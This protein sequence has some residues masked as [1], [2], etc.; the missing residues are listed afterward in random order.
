M[1]LSRMLTTKKFAAWWLMLAAGVVF[2]GIG[3]FA[4]ID[5]LNSYLKL[6]KFTGIALLL[7]GGMLLTLAI[8]NTKYPGER[9]W[10]QAESILHLFFG[11]L[12]LFNPLLYFI[13]LPFFIGVWVLLVGVLKIFAAISLRHSIRGWMFI[14]L[15][16]VICALFGTLLIFIPLPKATG[17]TVLIGVFGL[18][19]GSLYTFDAYRYRKTPESI[20]MML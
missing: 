12:F 11:I 8:L 5:P 1:Y 2:I 17:I 3:L 10:Q 9:K 6:V 18:I 4:F 7:N 19:M 15:V 16:G 20:G 14:L 13:A